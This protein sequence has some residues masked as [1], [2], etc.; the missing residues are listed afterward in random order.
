MHYCD[1]I[2]GSLLKLIDRRQFDAIVD[3]HN[4]NAYDKKFDSW[5]HLV[6]LIGAQLSGAQSLRELEAAWQATTI[7]WGLA[8]SA[9]RHCRMPTSGDLWRSSPSCS[10]VWPDKLPG[11]GGARVSRWS[12]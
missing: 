12:D 4:G 1:S 3:R 2:F 8:N 5:N 7:T 6:C 10:A 9:D 11:R